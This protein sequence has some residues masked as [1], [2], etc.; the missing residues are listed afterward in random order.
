M[1]KEKIQ[2]LP[3]SKKILLIGNGPSALEHDMGD[4][5]DSEFDYVCRINRGH[6]QDNGELNTGFEKQVGS[7]CDIWF[8]SD[9]R[10]E[11]AIE[12]RN[13][14]KST[15]IYYPSFKFDPYLYEEMEQEFKNVH[16]LN[17]IFEDNINEIVN[18]KPQWPS[19]GV[20]AMDFLIT[21]NSY[22]NAP[23]ASWFYDIYI[24]GF[25]TYD[26]KYNNL[27]YFE[28]KPNK[29]QNHNQSDHTPQLEKDYINYMINNKKI[30]KLI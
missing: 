14:Y 2:Q 24:Y 19:T 22:E 29:Y 6:K 16:I 9:L 11:L 27:H 5:I 21:N 17:P 25:D 28:N 7:K 18:F 30:K 10:L 4:R 20:V 26:V 15:Y 3:A 23:S 1:I 8:C 12:R 13:D